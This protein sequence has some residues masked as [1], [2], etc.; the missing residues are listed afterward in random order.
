MG[1]SCRCAHATNLTGD[2][3]SNICVEELEAISENFQY[4][5]IALF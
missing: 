1:Q 3:D 5:D 4:P 2:M